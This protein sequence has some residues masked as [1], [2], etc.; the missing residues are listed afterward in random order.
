MKIIVTG[1]TGMVGSAFKNI[2]TNH[3]IVLVGSKDYDLTDISQTRQMISKNEPDG[4]IHLAAKVGGVKGNKTYMNDYFVQ[5]LAINMNVLQ[6][7]HNMGVSKVVSLLST[8]VYPDDVVFPLT[9]E[10]IHSGYPH[11]SNFGYAYAK[12]MA[13]IHSRTLRKQYGRKYICAV[14]NNLYGPHDNFDLENGHVAAAIFRKIYEAKHLGIIP[15]FW[16]NGEPLREF[17]YSEDVAKILL[18]LIENYDEEQPINIGNT[19][20]I[21]IREMVTLVS[22]IAGYEGE[23]QWDTTKPTG[24]FRKPSCNNKFI[25]LNPNFCYTDFSDG[26]RNTYSWFSKT[27]PKVRGVK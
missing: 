14:P 2:N 22:K 26:L 11:H 5:N 1:G 19:Q 18:F 3:E 25:Q 24:Q 4:I 23:I 10:E 17:T 9:E 8:C 16:G 21:S 12:R 6:Q 7:S 13:D 15:K 20:E 27:Y